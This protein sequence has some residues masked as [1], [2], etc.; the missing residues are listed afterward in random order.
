MEEEGGPWG[1][2]KRLTLFGVKKCVQIFDAKFKI[3]K[4]D[5]KASTDGSV[6]GKQKGDDRPTFGVEGGGRESTKRR[7]RCFLATFSLEKRQRKKKIT[8]ANSTEQE[9]KAKTGH[10][11]DILGRANNIRKGRQG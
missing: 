2:C 6:G 1:G 9:D 7:L 10:K 11:K 3:R 4:G 8:K 5:I